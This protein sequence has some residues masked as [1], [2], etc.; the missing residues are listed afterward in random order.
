MLPGGSGPAST[1][2]ALGGP[3]APS[4]ER[5]YDPVK[6]AAQTYLYT[7]FTKATGIT[8]L[9]Y[10]NNEREWVKLSLTLQTVG[11]V[12]VGTSQNIEPVNSGKGQGLQSG[13]PTVIVLPPS[14]RLFII[15][16]TVDRVSFSIEP[17]PWLWQILNTIERIAFVQQGV[18]GGIVSGMARVLKGSK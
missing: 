4:V 7:F 3:Q 18:V 14:Q 12:D 13:I 5:K 15:S 1:I 11:P 17:L 8:E 2:A 6:N 9:I 10:S 16:N